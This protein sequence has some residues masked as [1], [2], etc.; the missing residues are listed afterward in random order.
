M[1]DMLQLPYAFARASRLM[2]SSFSNVGMFLF[3]WWPAANGD[4]VPTFTDFDGALS[5][6]SGMPTRYSCALQMGPRGGLCG[7]TDQNHGDMFYGNLG[8]V[9]CAHR[10]AVK[11]SQRQP[12]Q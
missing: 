12:V 11:R 3:T 4:A 2:F 7:P 6:A 5:N 1:P 8:R 9:S 10:L